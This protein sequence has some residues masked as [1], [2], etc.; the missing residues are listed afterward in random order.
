LAVADGFVP[1][2]SANAVDPAAGPA[3]L[4]LKRHDLDTRDPKLVFRGRVLDEKGH[5][6][7]DAVVEPA[8]F[9][10]GDRGSFG[11]LKGFDPLALTNPKGEFR[12]GVPEAGLELFVKVEARYFARRAFSK[13]PADRS[14]DLT[15]F[16]GVTVTGRLVKGGKPLPGGAVGLVQKDRDVETFVGEYQAAADEKGVFRIPNVPPN[17]AYV[18]YGLMDSLKAH[19][20]VPGRPCRTGATGTT[21]DFGDLTVGPGFRLTGRLELSDG[22]PAPAGT[23]VLINRQEAWDSQQAVV[24]QDGSFAFAGLPAERYGLS[25]NV[26]GY[27]ASS[28]NASFDM[29][30]PFGLIGTVPADVTGLRLLYEPGTMEF[31]RGEWDKAT[32]AEYDRRCKSPL[33]G[34]EEKGGEDR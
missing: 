26:R 22:K 32:A 21:Q 4:K 15:V 16:A 31:R 30:N 8:G 20:A 1:T 24:G 6:V 2:Q 11:G 9:Q 23:R 10:K 29:L 19:G 7:P 5:P 25:A 17:D 14:H 33:R 34:V 12:L 27:R 13:L 3:K 28:K 18:L